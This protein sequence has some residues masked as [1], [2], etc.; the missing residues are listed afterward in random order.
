MPY[1]PITSFSPVGSIHFLL[2]ARNIIIRA[3][4]MQFAN[5]ESDESY[6]PHRLLVQSVSIVV[7]LKVM[8]V[9]KTVTRTNCTISWNGVIIPRD[10]YRREFENIAIFF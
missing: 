10:C 5:K 1:E 2:F 4:S 3:I 7:L 8:N 6:V 9:S